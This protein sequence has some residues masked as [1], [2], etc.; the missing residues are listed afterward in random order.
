MKPRGKVAALRRL[1]GKG[2]PEGFT[3]A[4]FPNAP[5]AVAF[6]GMA[7][8]RLTDGRAHDYGQAIASA[9]LAI[10]TYEEL[11][12]GVNWFRRGLGAAGLAYVLVRLT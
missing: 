8:E 11:T 5:L 2:W 1:P 4:Q 12:E 6:A 10:W 3:I 7:V 9:G